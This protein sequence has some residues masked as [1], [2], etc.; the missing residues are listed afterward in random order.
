MRVHLPPLAN[1]RYKFEIKRPEWREAVDAC[2]MLT[3]VAYRILRDWHNLPRVPYIGPTFPH[4]EEDP[5][6]GRI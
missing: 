6:H 3:S 2:Q 4:I 5:F 1:F